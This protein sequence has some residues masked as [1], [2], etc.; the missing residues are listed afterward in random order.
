[1]LNYIKYKR[2]LNF[3]EN[4]MNVS[5][6]LA[7]NCHKITKPLLTNKKINNFVNN[8]TLKIL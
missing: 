8:I 7:L 1:M 6:K 3:I 5:L 4:P 2:S